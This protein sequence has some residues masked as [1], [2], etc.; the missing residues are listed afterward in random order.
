MALQ[1][2][3]AIHV[4][5]HRAGSAAGYHITSL[6]IW[7]DLDYVEIILGLQMYRWMVWSREVY[8]EKVY[9]EKV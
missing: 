6:P 4:N 7:G 8:N 1:R 9:D 3:V 5:L 2:G